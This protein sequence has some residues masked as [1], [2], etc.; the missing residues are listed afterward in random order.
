MA[1]KTYYEVLEVR[2]KASPEVIS[3][4]Y[5]RL[6]ARYDPTRQ[7]NPADARVRLR[8]AALQ[9][10]DATLQALSNHMAPATPFP[11]TARGRSQGARGAGNSGQGAC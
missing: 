2:H 6:C 8:M 9:D 7:G 4:A 10:A 1:R 3:A 5:E 11:A